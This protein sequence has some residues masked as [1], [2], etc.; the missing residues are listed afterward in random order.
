MEKKDIVININTRGKYGS[1]KEKAL[2]PNE[3]VRIYSECKDN[4]DKIIFILSAYAGLRVGE[5]TQVRTEWLKRDKFG[6]KEVLSIAIPNECRDLRNKYK[7]WKPKT[8]NSRTTY[9]FSKELWLEV[10]NYFKYNESIG[11]SLRGIQERCYRLTKVSIHGMRAT[12]QNY[13]KYEMDLPAEVI[14]VF[15]GHKDIRTTLQHYNT[16]N[17]AQA[18]SFLIQ[19]YK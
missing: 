2:T 13:F 15:L 16:L 5:I 14:A 3:R 17:K 10:E 19:R 9:L 18:E 1:A 4:K 12:A 8:K 11:L 7:I 6:D